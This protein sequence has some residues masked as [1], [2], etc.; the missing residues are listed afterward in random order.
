MYICMYIY[1]YIIYMYNIIYHDFEVYMIK[2]KPGNEGY[3]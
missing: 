2:Y 1:V 3:C